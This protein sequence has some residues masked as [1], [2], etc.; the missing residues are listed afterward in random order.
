MC[1]LIKLLEK[2]TDGVRQVDVSGPKKPVYPYAKAI[3]PSGCAHAHWSSLAGS[4][5]LL[6]DKNWVNQSINQFIYTKTRKN[7]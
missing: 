5:N 3:Q 2:I 1:V 4:F 7:N 6:N